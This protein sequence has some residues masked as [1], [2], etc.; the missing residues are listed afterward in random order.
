MDQNA[1]QST[2]GAAVSNL[3]NDYEERYRKLKKKYA[4]LLQEHQKVLNEFEKSNDEIRIL[5]NEKAFLKNKI[6]DILSRNGF[7]VQSFEQEE[8]LKEGG[9]S[10]N[11]QIHKME[12][13]SKQDDSAI[14]QE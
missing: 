12:D 2:S 6:N 4:L 8:Q 3:P 10:A 7:D 1:Q 11:E 9:Q 14:Q 13:F 5:N